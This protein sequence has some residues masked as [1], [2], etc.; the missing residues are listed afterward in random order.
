[1]GQRSTS[2]SI[3]DDDALVVGEIHGAHGIRGEVRV[4][5]LTDVP[6][7]FHEGAL[8]D[9]DGIGPLTIERIRGDATSR[10]VLF[11]GYGSRDAVESL[12]GRLLRVPREES[13]RA[14]KDAYLWADLVGLD[15]VTPDGR[16]LGKVRDLLRA[17]GTDVLVVVGEQGTE[18]LHAMIDTVVRD[19][20]V[21]ARRIVLTPQE[22]LG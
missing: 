9:C 3:N 13:R 7:R 12:K 1:M 6:T 18:T 21:H 17:G 2:R 16:P 4:E 15:A 19:I 14:T 20:D 8:F 11:A 22:D 5:P 10:I